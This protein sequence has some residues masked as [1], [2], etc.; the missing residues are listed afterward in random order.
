MSD[1]SY[2]AALAEAERLARLSDDALIEQLGLRVADAEHNP[3]GKQRAQSFSAPFAHTAE[4]LLSTEDLRKLG[5]R[6][7]G[8]LQREIMA[9]ICDKNREEMSKIT[10]GKT[11]PQ[12]A[13][14]LA[15]AGVVAV[16]AA[17]PAWIIVATSLVAAKI[18]ETG[19][20]AMCELWSERLSWRSSVLPWCGGPKDGVEDAD[21]AADACDDGELFRSAACDELGVV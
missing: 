4:D 11:I 14:S 17:P 13:A 18:A 9:I 16:V 8:K 2:E 7:W 3:G 20:D 12:I 1:L 15:T 6:W 10:G 19:I 21:E 5:R